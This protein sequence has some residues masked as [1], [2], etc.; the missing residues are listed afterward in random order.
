MSR[1]VIARGLGFLPVVGQCEMKGGSEG[2]RKDKGMATF[3]AGFGDK[4]PLLTCFAFVLEI[5]FAEL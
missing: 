3:K 2:S 5:L 4:E 1:E